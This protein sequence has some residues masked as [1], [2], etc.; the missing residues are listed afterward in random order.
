MNSK[1]IINILISLICIFPRIN[2]LAQFQ[3]TLY[4][5][6]GQT[7]VSDGLFIKMADLT[8]YRFGK[9]KLEAGLQI[10]ILSN[11]DRFF[12]GYNIQ[13]S[14]E[15]MIKS[16][17]LE[18]QAFFILSPFSDILRETNWGIL[19]G[20]Y[21]NHFTIEIGT[22]FRTYA[23]NHKAVNT[24]SFETDTRMHENWNL[25][26]S[27]NG[28][29]KPIDNVW[30][31]G[32]SITNMDHFI[33]NQET[34][35]VLNLRFAYKFKPSCRVY[36]EPWYESAGALNLKVNYFGFFIRSGI[37]WDINLTD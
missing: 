22:N 26:Y 19:L 34:N 33:I 35:P 18:T 25:M 5:D 20:I 17:P 28:Y 14:R 7:V 36:F 3:T 4:A 11:N 32:L 1:I 8:S 10:D 31:V 30:N 29:I 24:Y 13:V 2:L 21:R 15:W 23:Y 27:F 9:N 6:I 37:I 16:F 12:S